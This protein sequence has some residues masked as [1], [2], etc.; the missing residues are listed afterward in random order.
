MMNVKTSVVLCFLYQVLARITFSLLEHIT[1]LKTSLT[2]GLCFSLLSQESF[3]PACWWRQKISQIAFCV[4]FTFCYLLHGQNQFVCVCAGFD[5]IGMWSLP[6][7]DTAW[8]AT[9]WR[10]ALRMWFYSSLPVYLMAIC[11]I[12][13]G[14]LNLTLEKQ[15]SWCSVPMLSEVLYVVW[16]KQWL[17]CSALN[18]EI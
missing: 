16:Q 15:C 14:Q 8:V 6:L 4:H 2:Q 17:A 5:C 12:F 1:L 13:S 11:C 18:F 9:C 7:C 10:I 3:F